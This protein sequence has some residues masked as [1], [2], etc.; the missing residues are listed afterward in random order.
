MCI[1][2]AD[3][4]SL[5]TKHRAAIFNLLFRRSQWLG[6]CQIC[7]TITLV[8][9]PKVGSGVVLYCFRLI[10]LCFC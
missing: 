8:V 4:A 2:S 3:F 9:F 1:D 5:I 7:C 6:K 10:M